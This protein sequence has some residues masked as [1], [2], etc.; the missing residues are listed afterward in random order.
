MQPA[1]L[2][3]GATGNVV[4]D[5]TT[6]NALPASGK[7]KV[8]FP[9]GFDLTGIGAGAAAQTSVAGTLAV[10]VSGQVVTITSDAGGDIIATATA[11]SVTLSG[12]KNPTTAGSGGT[13]AIQTTQSNDTV[14]N[15]DASVATDTLVAGAATAGSSTVTANPTSVTAN[16]AGSRSAKKSV[17]NSARA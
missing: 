7:I 16:G 5:F 14:I 2:V 4:V 9:T 15:S 13:Y 17:P 1:S 10:A 3:A 6:A 12:I 11:A 8:T